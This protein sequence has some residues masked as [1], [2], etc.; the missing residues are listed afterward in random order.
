MPFQPQPQPNPFY[1]PNL[2]RHQKLRQYQGSE[3]DFG[4]SFHYNGAPAPSDDGFDR[5]TIED[6]PA[7]T[8][9]KASSMDRIDRLSTFME[10]SKNDGHHNYTLRKVDENDVN[11]R[12]ARNPY[13]GVIIEE[14]LDSASVHSV[15]Y[16]LVEADKVK[17]ADVSAL[18]P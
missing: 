13:P 15:N 9:L 18:L 5:G 12:D 4:E 10:N 8:A 1:T 7:L 2:K 11:G 6:T 14:M 17:E 3:A 16:P